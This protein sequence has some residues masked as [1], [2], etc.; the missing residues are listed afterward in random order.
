MDETRAQRQ[1]DTASSRRCSGVGFAC[2]RSTGGNGPRRQAAE[3][4]AHQRADAG[5]RGRSH[6]ARMIAVQDW[7]E[8][9]KIGTKMIM[10]VHDELVLE[11]PEGEVAR[12]CASGCRN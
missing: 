10:Q 3:R 1:A 8:A 4:A 7:L 12:R 11:V 9:S 5:H 6:Q 2:P